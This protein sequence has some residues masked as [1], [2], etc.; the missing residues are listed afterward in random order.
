MKKVAGFERFDDIDKIKLLLSEESFKIINLY[1]QCLLKVILQ[2]PDFKSDLMHTVIDKD[3]LTEY[4]YYNGI[5]I[6]TISHKSGH[7]NDDFIEN[8]ISFV[9]EFTPELR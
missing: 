7:N 1:N 6:G 4:I 5:H 3:L 2:I 9:V 8:K